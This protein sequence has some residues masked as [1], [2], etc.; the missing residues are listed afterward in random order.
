MK[1]TANLKGKVLN[2]LS[3]ACWWHKNPIF[4]KETSVRL[5][6]EEARINRDF[7]QSK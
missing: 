5:E 6:Y 1:P 3:I 4:P 7:K 2:N